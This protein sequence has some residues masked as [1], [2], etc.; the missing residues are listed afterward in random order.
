MIESIEKELKYIVKR[1]EFYILKKY[2]V[3]CGF[4]NNT[5]IQSNYYLDTS[6]YTLKSK[7]ITLRLREI[8]HQE[9]Y[10]TVKIKNDEVI[11]NLHIKK[12][13]NLKINKKRFNLIKS[14]KD[15][16]MHLDILDPIKNVIGYNQYGSAIS[17]RGCLTTK[18]ISYKIPGFHEPILLD[19]NIYLNEV[20][21]EIEWETEK[22]DSALQKIKTIF[23]DL[24]ITI[25]LNSISK[26]KRF[27]K[28][29]R[30]LCK[31]HILK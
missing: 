26:S 27:I 9:Y 29:Q 30:Q 24:G 18:R 12:E 11:N 31:E 13:F 15:I 3:S 10:L 25:Q 23:D 5:I 20:D 28:L 8:N 1:N 4:P 14:T 19:K 16:R 2:L 22:I 6:D 21:Y 7:G 17:M